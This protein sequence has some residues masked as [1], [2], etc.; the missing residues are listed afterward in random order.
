MNDVLTA[1]PR[2]ALTFAISALC[3]FAG[4]FIGLP[5]GMLVGAA[6]GVAVAAIAGLPMVL[7][8]PLRNVTFLLVGMSMG[9]AVAPD[10][11]SL[12][13]QW[14]ISIAGL[15]LELVLIISVTGWVLVRFFGLDT[16]TAY[17]SSFPGHLSFVMSIASAGVGEPR[18]II[19][20]QVIRLLM[21]TIAV[22]IGALFL[23]IGEGVA[24]VA[25]AR[26]TLDPLSIVLL[27]A[28]CALTGFVFEKLRIPAGFVLG[29]M[30]AA[31]IGKL[32]G[33]YDA[34]LP[35]PLV[36]A[37]FIATGALIGVRFVGMTWAEFKR[38]AVGGLIAT[39]ITVGITTSISALV[40]LLVDMPFGQIWLGLSPGA[41]EGMGALTLALG[42]DTAFVAAHHV[43]RLLLLSFAIPGVVL[44]IRR[45]MRREIAAAPP[46]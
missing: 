2:V 12:V 14:P 28:G 9:A 27:A 19:M 11:L 22:P 15:V 45:Q 46:Q 8:T 17:M 43:I 1:A 26:E 33:L 31:T 3:G 41:L 10:S 32:A 18:Q 24:T 44:L 40:S 16:G 29:A 35:E 42:Y 5:A 36:I 30:G 39:L 38:I 23:P 4:H 7:P 25:A 6:M 37:T 20:I 34:V 13:V 21:L